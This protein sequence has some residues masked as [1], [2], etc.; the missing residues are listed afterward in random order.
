MFFSAEQIREARKK[1][2]EVSKASLNSE[3]LIRVRTHVASASTKMLWAKKMQ[4]LE[5]TEKTVFLRG[6]EDKEDS[7]EA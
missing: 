4:H 5:E 1:A 6:A 3:G 7:H 2:A